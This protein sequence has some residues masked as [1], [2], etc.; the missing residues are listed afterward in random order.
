MT[1]DNGTSVGAYGAVREL[2]LA[3]PDDLSFIAFDNL[4]WTELVTPALTVVEQ[5]VYDLGMRAAEL[6]IRRVQGDDTPAREH[7]LET[8]FIER[9]STRVV[10]RPR[11][12]RSAGPGVELGAV[13]A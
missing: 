3:V 1:V 6:I 12:R 9:E 13:R 5:P 10:G 4:D 8:R 7:L 11:R 2:G